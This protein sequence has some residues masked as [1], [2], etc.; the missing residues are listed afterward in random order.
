MR[1]RIHDLARRVNDLPTLPEIY[2]QIES[3]SRDPSVSSPE[4]AQLIVRDP[5]LSA[6]ILR[7]VNSAR[8]ALSDRV[9]T[10]TRAVSILG[11]RTVRD[12]VLV[13]SVFNLLPQ[14]PGRRRLAE[15]FW[16]HS[17]AVGAATAVLGAPGGGR[18]AE[19]FFVAGLLHD[20]GKL[21]WLRFYPEEYE[22][23]AAAAEATG[24]TFLESEQAMAGTTHVRL[25]RLLARRWR[26]PDPLQDAVGFHHESGTVP[27][28]NAQLCR[29]VQAADA[30]VHALELDGPSR[31]PVPAVAPDVWAA[32]RVEPDGV[33][34]LL[35]AIVA[36]YT[37]Q[38]ERYPL[39]PQE[40][41]DGGARA[42][43]QPVVS[44]V[45]G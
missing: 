13:T 10:V 27:G 32:L 44:H 31:L 16:R 7:L 45:A 17:L 39:A 37:D 33:P 24:L 12:A 29:A 5:V 34:T 8:Y 1:D 22:A 42:A 4:L 40:P 20:L 14:E 36:E 26:L 21:F 30:V 11:H 18:Q 41:A 19:E 28:A 23:M 35:D 25:G 15:A 3:A 38:L 9:T 43:E 2:R 6:R